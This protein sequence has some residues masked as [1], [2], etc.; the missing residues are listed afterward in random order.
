MQ[1]FAPGSVPLMGVPIVY[2]NQIK[3][4]VAPVLVSLGVPPVGISAV[5]DAVDTIPAQAH[6]VPWM[7]ASGIEQVATTKVPPSSGRQEGSSGPSEEDDVCTWSSTGAPGCSVSATR[8]CRR[9]RRAGSC[10]YGETCHF[11]HI[12]PFPGLAAAETRAPCEQPEDFASPKSCLMELTAEEASDSMDARGADGSRDVVAPATDLSMVDAAES[13]LVD[14]VLVEL[15]A[16]PADAESKRCGRLPQR[17]LKANERGSRKPLPLPLRDGH[18]EPCRHLLGGACRDGV[19]CR[20]SHLLGM[21]PQSVVAEA[22]RLRGCLAGHFQFCW[23]DKH[24]GLCSRTVRKHDF[25]RYLVVGNSELND[26]VRDRTP[27]PSTSSEVEAFAAQ[28]LCG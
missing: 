27:P 4:V 20:C 10:K 19:G 17:E 6:A 1:H 2:A 9:F 7:Q 12:P 25:D 23:S 13:R 22:E 14:R 18:V 8:P 24:G 3:A 28:A 21:D 26:S 5:F 16:D 11:L 15:V